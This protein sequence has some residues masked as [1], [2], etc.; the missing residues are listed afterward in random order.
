MSQPQVPPVSPSTARNR[1][2]VDFSS[3]VSLLLDNISDVLGVPK[4][5][6]VM[7]ALLDALPGL[8][9]RAEGLK[10]KADALSQKRR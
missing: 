4:S 3:S 6:L 8:V 1:V 9:E 10:K 2:S 7:Q 5:Q